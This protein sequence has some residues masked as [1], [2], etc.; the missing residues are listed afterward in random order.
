MFSHAEIL[1]SRICEFVHY[2]C[3]NF[4]FFRRLAKENVKPLGRQL[5]K[6]SHTSP[7]VVFEYVCLS[8][9]TLFIIYHSVDS[10]IAI[11]EYIACT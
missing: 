5:G 4:V 9:C 3:N 10:D 7:G 6:L 2:W 8:F 1:R 11:F